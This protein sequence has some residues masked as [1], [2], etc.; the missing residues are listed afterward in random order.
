MANDQV[1][2]IKPLPPFT[3]NPS[4]TYKDPCSKTF[5]S[6]PPPQPFPTQE[7][8]DS[9]WDIYAKT[10]NGGKKIDKIYNLQTAVNNNLK[11]LQPCAKSQCL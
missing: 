6:V 7:Q 8:R 3:S 10:V 4:G 1:D 2:P 9:L 11:E 5:P